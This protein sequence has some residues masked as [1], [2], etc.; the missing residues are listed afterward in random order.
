MKQ[1]LLLFILIIFTNHIY[2]MCSSS[3]ISVWPKTEKISRKSIFIIEGYAMTQTIIQ[4]LNKEH[5]IYLKSKN[6]IIDLEVLK[7]N[8][9]GYRLTQAVL[10]PKKELTAGEY[11]TLEI[12][13]LNAEEKKLLSEEKHKWLVEELIDNKNPEWTKEPLLLNKEMSQY[14]CGPAIY[15]N[16]CFCA[17]ETS[18]IA[19]ITRLK[20]LKTGNQYEYYVLPI[21]N[22]LTIGHS[23]CA[24]EFSF[25]ENEK[26]E[27]CFS[28]I[29]ASGNTDAKFTK[30][31]SF[32]S[33][34]EEDNIDNEKIPK[35]ECELNIKT[36]K[37]DEYSILKIFSLIILLSTFAVFAFYYYKKKKNNH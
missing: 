17:N 9:G 32:T 26:Y 12:D 8:I 14:G 29:D 34:Q 24:G 10:K 13:G 36:I 11:Y 19:V 35:C 6:S 27:I 7:I 16:F 4:N 30:K 22:K 1:K 33:P 18:D 37:K 28:L 20:E 25:N 21:S 31:I 5:K 3:N 23:M 15:V 2:S